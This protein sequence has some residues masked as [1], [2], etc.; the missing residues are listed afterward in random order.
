MAI[1]IGEMQSFDEGRRGRG[2][3]ILGGDK[4]CIEDIVEMLDQ[5]NEL[6]V[7]WAGNKMLSPK[8]VVN[9]F[10]KLG[11]GTDQPILVQCGLWQT[12][13]WTPPSGV[14]RM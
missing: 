3:K 8:R 12:A 13:K 10:L 4:P 14:M 11:R 6:T 2:E 1:G 9:F 7:V 5:R